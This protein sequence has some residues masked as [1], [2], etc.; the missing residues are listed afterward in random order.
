MGPDVYI[1]FIKDDLN[2]PLVYKLNW[3]MDEYSLID[4]SCSFSYVDTVNYA[5]E[6]RVFS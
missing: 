1:N 5:N 2:L 3:A 6:F 4:V